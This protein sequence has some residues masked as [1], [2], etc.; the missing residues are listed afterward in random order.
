MVI[1]IM[2]FAIAIDRLENKRKERKESNSRELK[3]K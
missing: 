2:N 1:A 3:S